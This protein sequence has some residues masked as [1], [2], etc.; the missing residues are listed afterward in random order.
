MFLEVVEEL[1]EES[2]EFWTT[3]RELVWVKSNDL[4]E[5]IWLN[6]ADGL[7]T[8]ALM[9]DDGFNLLPELFRLDIWHV[10][11]K[12][13]DQHKEI[14]EFSFDNPLFWLDGLC[15]SSNQFYV[16]VCALSHFCPI[17]EEQ[18]ILYCLTVHRIDLWRHNQL[19]FTREEWVWNLPNTKWNETLDE[20]GKELAF[21]QAV[22]VPVEVF[23]LL[24]E[25]FIQAPRPELIWNILRR[26]LVWEEHR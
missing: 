7:L 15:D 12:D 25:L 17:K 8:E 20:I 6:F 10:L 3:L 5:D 2:D 11:V 21:V 1:P 24:I 19:N 13:I 18:Q 9:A 4:M 26:Q 14:L 16:S 23:D 22:F